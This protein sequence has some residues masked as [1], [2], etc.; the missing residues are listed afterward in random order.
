MLNGI[1]VTKNSR[2]IGVV[3]ETQ[4]RRDGILKRVIQFSLNNPFALWIMTFIITVAGLYAGIHMKMETIPDIT[5]PIVNVTTPY[6]GAEPEEVALHVTEAIERQVR[7]LDGVTV[8]SSQSF[9]NASSVV[10]EYDY[11]K[12]MEEAQREVEESLRAL[13][14]PKGAGE[15]SVSRLSLNAFPVLSLSLSN[16]RQSLQELTQTVEERVVPSLKGLKGVADIQ[17]SGQ[18]VQEVELE[19]RAE[20]MRELGLSEETVKSII[21]GSAITVPLGVFEFGNTEK[22]LLVD[23]NI[24][25]EEDLRSLHIPLIPSGTAGARPEAQSIAAAPQ[26]AGTPAAIPQADGSSAAV[27]TVK[28]GD[29]ADIRTIGKAESISRTNGL[30]AIGLAIVK[31]PEA[32]TVEVVRL[33]KKEVA[34]LEA[35]IEGLTAVAVLDQGQP[36]EESVRTMMSKALLGAVFSVIIILLFLRNFRSTIIAVISIP[37]SILLALL[38]LQQTSITLNIMTLGAMTVAIGRVVDDSIVVIENIYR[39]MTWAEERLSGKQLVL[40]ATREM[41]VPIMASTMVTIAVFLPLGLVSGPVGQM[42]MPFA[43]TIVLALLAS[44]L[45][46]VTIVPML[47]YTLFRKGLDDAGLRNTSR[48]SRR[49]HKPQGR[50]AQGYKS[51]LAWSLNHKAVAFGAAVILLAASLFTVPLVGTSF[52]DTGAEKM[53]IV[54]YSP[55]P[56]ETPKQVEQLALQAEAALLGREGVEVLQYSVG[57]QNPLNPGASRQAL[58]YLKYDRD[59]AN[60][61]GEQQQ[62]IDKLKTV[63][64]SGEWKNVDMAG[65]GMGGSSLSLRVYGPDMAALKPVVDELVRRL[66]SLASLTNIDS[67]ISAVYGQ[68]RVVADSAKLSRFALTAG[69]VAA[70]LSP[71]RERPVLTTIKK[72]AN[73]VNVYVKEVEFQYSGL[74]DLENVKIRSPLGLDVALKDVAAIEEG[75]SPNTISRR[76]DKVYAEITAETTAKDIGAV[77][78]EMQAAVREMKLPEGVSVE[79]G[80]VTEQLN[81]SFSQLGMA[82]LAAVAIVYLILV[83]TF[84]GAITPFTI[85]FSLPFTVIGAL[86][87]LWLAGE[88][89]SVTAMIGMLMLIGIV[90][91]NAIVLIDRVIQKEKEGLSVR[92]ALLE[93]AGTRLRPILMTALATI[94]A[95]LPLAFGFESGALISKGLGVT[96]IGGLTSSTLLTLIIVPVVYEWLN[97]GRRR[98]RRREAIAE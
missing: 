42:F 3:L 45:I 44:L 85:L 24:V 14:L 49:R 65:G 36:I 68:Y 53:I 15:P 9:Q 18:Q 66:H 58:F 62:I 88:T 8:V 11:D 95:L 16:P 32:N 17:I 84:G 31:G 33:V 94:G 25:S 67:S 77:S 86:I 72:D 35:E 83:I 93:A 71:A 57:G 87:G 1:Q 51:V 55:A 41:I 69:Q 60:F 37:L 70:A 79:Q 89:I 23:G 38:G 12:D 61:A 10:I 40:E 75:E 27:P 80:G 59:Y 91:T 76:G 30:E 64:G 7:S 26:A 21:Q 97:R 19:F 73:N 46:A 34:R 81:E 92:E 47:A 82:M 39:R 13:H 6:P 90:V 43:L 63:G 2:V 48:R 4:R 96:V 52:I 22:A 78:R 5:V 28:L 29:I 50:L 54:A 98:R 74:A 20:K 56:G